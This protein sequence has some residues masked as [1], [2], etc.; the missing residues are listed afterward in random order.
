MIA[1]VENILNLLF[2]SKVEKNDLEAGGVERFLDCFEIM[3]EARNADRKWNDTK[4]LEGVQTF[5]RLMVNA[6]DEAIFESASITLYSFVFRTDFFDEKEKQ[7]LN[8]RF[9]EEC[10][11]TRW[12]TCPARVH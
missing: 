2:H 12:G 1:K 7:E 3:H 6:E 4:F 8:K 5:L 11:R 10:V 9:L